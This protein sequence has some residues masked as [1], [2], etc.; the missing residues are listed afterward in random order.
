MTD[1]IKEFLIEQ[2]L[3][4]VPVLLFIGKLLKATPKIADWL[5]PWLLLLAGAGGGLAILGL[6]VNALVQGVLAAAMAVFGHQLYKQTT[7]QEE[8]T[9]DSLYS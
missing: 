8:V 4:L 3:I 5:I 7:E 6:T 2:V 1:L 9:Y